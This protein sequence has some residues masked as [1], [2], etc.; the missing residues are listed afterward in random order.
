MYFARLETQPTFI[1]ANLATLLNNR[2][3]KLIKP[4]ICAL[5]ISFSAVLPAAE[6][7]AA[8]NSAPATSETKTESTETTPADRTPPDLSLQQQEDLARALAQS[9]ETEVIWLTLKDEKQLALLQ[10]AATA[11]PTGTVI[12]FSDRSTSSD[13]PA[14]VHPLRTQLTGFGWNTLSITLPQRPPALIPK[15]TLPTL[16]DKKDIQ[17]P[18]DT[19]DAPTTEQTAATPPATDQRPDSTS[20]AQTMTEYQATISELGQQATNQLANVSGD[21]KIILGVGEGATWA[22]HYFM[23]DETQADRF[24]VLLDPR[25]VMD[26]DAPDLLQMISAIKAPVL[27]L[28]FNNTSV[29]QQRADLRKRAASRSGNKDYRQF[30]L[31]QRRNDSR[32]KPLWLTYQLRG[33]LKTY[34]VNAQ[35]PPAPAPQPKELAPGQ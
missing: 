18:A 3:M 10:H 1:L 29:K 8:D 11:T 35:K 34:V 31:N 26:E 19:E 33:I 24:L 22:M 20:A 13:W 21:I 6:D 27:D 9:P 23:Q 14:I 32:V 5:F 16:K 15:R 2:S 7:S 25:P 12:I 30:R 17:K 28:W 4:L